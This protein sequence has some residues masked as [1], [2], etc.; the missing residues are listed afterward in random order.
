LKVIVGLGN[1]GIFY[2]RTRHNLGFLVLDRL[3]ER[4]KLKFRKDP[5]LKA[6]KTDSKEIVLAKPYVFMNLSGLSVRKIKDKFSLKFQD[7]LVICDDLSLPL[8]KIRIRPKGSSGGHKGLGSVIECLQNQDFPRLR[9]GVGTPKADEDTS[10]FVLSRFSK[11]E[12]PEVKD[13]LLKSTE[14]ALAWI[15][16]DIQEV[17]AKFN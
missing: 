8:G 2:K 1:P 5:S 14:C 15:E 16:S 3:A 6:W 4:F 10:R 17:M 13:S 9:I 12:I 7:I 11:D